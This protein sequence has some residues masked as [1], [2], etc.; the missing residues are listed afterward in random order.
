MSKY[1]NRDSR[2]I[3]K[4]GTPVAS[5]SPPVTPSRVDRS[6]KREPRPKPLDWT[7]EPP[8]RS[9]RGRLVRERKVERRFAWAF[10][11]VVTVTTLYLTA[12]LP[13]G[14]ALL[15]HWHVKL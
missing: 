11:V 3:H 5:S 12:R 6:Q 2:L 8:S 15:G 10:G 4:E 7:S 13:W 1:I 14:M 9:A